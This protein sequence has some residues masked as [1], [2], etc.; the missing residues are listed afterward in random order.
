MGGEVYGA[1]PC[2]EGIPQVVHVPYCSQCYTTV[3]CTLQTNGETD[4]QTD[5]P[6]D[7]PTDTPMERQTYRLMDQWTNVYVYVNVYIQ[8][9]YTTIYI[10]LFLE[11]PQIWLIPQ[12]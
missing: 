6:M 7:R 12:G 4:R 11:I 8:F 9:N 2:T 1:T 5:G 10:F 3:Q